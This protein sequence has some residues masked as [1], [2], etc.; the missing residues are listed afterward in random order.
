MAQLLTNIFQNTNNRLRLLQVFGLFWLITFLLYLPAAKSGM[1]GDFP[2]YV[3]LIKQQTLW[4]YINPKNSLVLYQTMEL[5]MY[6][7]YKLFGLH[8]WPWHLFYVS[9]H[10]VNG[11]LLF[12]F[13]SNLL[14]DSGVKNGAIL[15]FI[16][17]CL[18]I[19]CPHASEAV[20]WKPANHFLLVPVLMFLILVLV[21]QYLKNQKPVYAV[22]SWLLF[23]YSSFSL[24]FFYLMPWLVLMLLVYSRIAAGTDKIIFRKSFL[25]FFVPLVLLFVVH[26]CLLRLQSNT[27]VSH[28]G[29]F[30]KLPVLY[31]LNK[32][33][34]YVFHIIFF[35]RFFHHETRMHIYEICESLT[36]VI[37]FYGVCILLWA[38][39]LLRLKEA[40]PQLKALAICAAFSLLCYLFLSALIFSDQLLVSLDRYTYL[41]NGFAYLTLV[42]LINF[43]PYR[44]IFYLIT[45]SYGLVNIYATL[46]INKYWKQSANIISNL[47]TNIPDPGN[48]TILLLNLPDDLRGVPM[49][50]A[51]PEGRF[52]IMQNELTPHPL[53]N[54][55]YDV[56]AYNMDAATD[57]AHVMVIN[58]SMLHVTLNQWGTW[59]LYGFLGATSYTNEDYK[60]NMIDEGHWYELTLK[61]PVNQYLLLYQVGDKWK[62][63]DWDKKNV[64][65]Y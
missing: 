45:F 41:A 44:S 32:P 59:W 30:D 22:I 18:F 7:L 1:V 46:K 2:Y 35:G 37:I 21:Q 5:T 61:H 49:I 8:P 33:L 55:M 12:S 15:S 40:A 27:F 63:V 20:V 10:A 29:H 42:L 48:K 36:A 17:V 26:L 23:F 56:S 39:V 54:N 13:F 25:W 50:A 14:K 9:L 51:Q 43:I 3:N 62:T 16:S 64:D 6:V 52:K 11:L 19:I 57:G 28:Y 58:D 34:K 53:R 65:Q 4:E 24:E 47:I 31:Y 60:L 38:F